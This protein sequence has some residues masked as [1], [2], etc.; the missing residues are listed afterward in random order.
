VTGKFTYAVTLRHELDLLRFRSDV[1]MFQQQDAKD[2]VSQVLTAAAIPAS[3]VAWRVTRTLPKRVYCVQYRESD[4]AFVSRLVED[5]GIFYVITDDSGGTKVTFADS[6]DAF[7]PID[8]DT[9]VPFVE[10]FGVGVREFW[11]ESSSTP[12]G[13]C[14]QDWNYETPSINLKSPS[15][16]GSDPQWGERFEFPGG[17]QTPADGSALAQIRMEEL[18]AQKV[19]GQGTS[20]CIAF[21]PGAWFEL[22]GPSNTKL[23]QKYV[24]RSVRH[25]FTIGRASTTSK[26]DYT[27]SFVCGPS[28]QAYRSPRLAPHARVHGSH[29]ILVTG[30]A[31]DEICTDKLGRMKGKFYWDRVGNDDDKAS[32]WIRTIQL[33]IG[34][35]MTLARVGWEMIVRYVHGDPDR[36]IAVARTDNGGFASPYAYPAANTAMSFKTLSS[37]GGAK[38]NE[39]K[40]EDS[41]SSMVWSM[42]AAKTYMEQ[43]KHDKTE[44][45]AV[46][47]KVDIGI[48]LDTSIGSNQKVTIGANQTVTVGADEGID[49]KGDRTKTV[50]ASETCT[51]SGNETEKI[52]GSDTETVGA[53]MTTMAALGINRTSKGSAA[54]TVGGSMLQ[55]A[56]MGCSLAVAG[57]R[58]ETVGAAKICAAGSDIKEGIIGALAVTV[59]GAIVHAAGGNRQSGSSASTAITVGGLGLANAGEKLQIKAPKIKITVAGACALVGGGGSLVLTPAAA[60]ATPMVTVKGDSGLKLKGSPNVTT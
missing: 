41:A 59:G 3:D 40:M 51:V 38:N 22:T 35:S 53:S 2:V 17:Y 15:T 30:A 55:L 19:V 42:N 52:T 48:D 11:L 16:Y 49:V 9:T 10:Q 21:R 29:S 44:K 27:N 14:L 33:P 58:S 24:L 18:I 39:V 36:P 34:S 12:D 28:D 6:K 32:C 43:S 4:F 7:A 31:G 57:A 46:D 60:I 45:V 8:G 25:E 20:D 54:I 47:E 26:P 56:A 50:G 1:R 37:P 23:A 13:V 5:E